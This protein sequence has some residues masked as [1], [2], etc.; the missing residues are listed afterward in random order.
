[1]PSAESADS[2]S[3]SSWQVHPLKSNRASN[4]TEVTTAGEKDENNLDPLDANC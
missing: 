4:L 3:K 1:M 2:I